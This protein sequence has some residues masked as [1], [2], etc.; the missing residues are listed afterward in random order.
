MSRT[1]RFTKDEIDVLSKSP[2]VKYIRENRLSF[3]YDFRC[4]LY[5]EWIK[6]PSVAQ[7][8]RVLTSY[9]FN[10]TIIGC[11]VINRLH[12]NFK[13]DGRPTGGKNKAFGIRNSLVEKY[14]NEFLIGS[15]IFMKFGKGIQFTSEFI[16]NVY[17]EYPKVSIESLLDSCGLDPKRVGFQRIYNLKKLFDGKKTVKENISLNTINK[18]IN[19][20]YVKR[21]TSKHFVLNNSFYNQASSFK[22]LPIDEV[23]GIFEIKGSDLPVDVHTRIKHKLNNWN[24]ESLNITDEV[25]L[26]FKLRVQYN[27]IQALEKMSLMHFNRLRDNLPQYTFEQKKALCMWIKELPHDR[28]DYSIQSIL[29]KIGLSRSSYYSILSNDN[30]GMKDKQDEIDFQHIKKVIDYK[31]FK[32]GSRTIY[33]MLPGMCGVHFGRAK[34]LRLMKKYGCVCTV[35]KERP[36]LKKSKENLKN[37]RKPNL[38]KRRFRLARPN[39]ILLTD[40]S[41]LK[42][43]TNK[44]EY[45]S[46]IKDAVTGRI[47]NHVT[48]SYNDLSL[49][50][51]TIACL[52]STEN[53]L[54]HSDQGTLYFNDEFQNKLKKLGYEQSMSRRGNCWDNSSQES[55]FGHMKDEC[56]FSKCSTPE[57]VKKKVDE[58]VYYYNYERP[59]W[60]RN[61]MT[62]VDYEKYLCSMSDGEYSEYMEI[63]QEKYDK[64]MEKAGIKAL[65]RAV[66]LGAFTQEKLELWLK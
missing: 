7:I 13:R 15:G 63:E 24:V 18:Y 10:C 31:G 36:E 2:Y 14:D 56:D 62:P 58:Y 48:S 34:I 17:K 20:P 47:V 54:F 1:K 4:I 55:Y 65:K 9:N 11:D 28:Y 66:E 22:D 35:R 42:Y 44:T 25:D 53:A 5:D 60:T 45:F 49:A 23:L 37:N 39:E 19:H 41:Y 8:R 38:L 43:S 51:D 40:V 59:Q 30:Y 6:Y 57:D 3:T 33:M 61:K 26:Y 29:K 64:M 16:D 32:K 46:C 52:E 27:K 12:R 21:C 50:T